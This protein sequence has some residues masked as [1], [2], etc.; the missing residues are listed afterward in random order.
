MSTET[1]FSV[2]EN[3]RKSISLCKAKNWKFRL[4]FVREK[5]TLSDG[6]LLDLPYF[7]TRVKMGVF[8]HGLEKLSPPLD[9]FIFIYLP[10]H[11]IGH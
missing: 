11:P 3:A 1:V 6:P 7:D 2:K 4:K 10:G 5:I 8:S 9:C